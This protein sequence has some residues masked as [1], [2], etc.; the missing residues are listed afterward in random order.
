MTTKTPPARRRDHVEMEQK[1]EINETSAARIL[2]KCQ[3]TLAAWRRKG[4]TGLP[5]ALRPRQVHPRLWAY[6]KAEV[7]AL[8]A[9]MMAEATAAA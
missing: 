3:N 2:G 7:E 5:M 8:R 6:V 9:A 4:F 1:G